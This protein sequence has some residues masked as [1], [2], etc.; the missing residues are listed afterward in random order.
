MTLVSTNLLP[1]L[2]AVI[3]EGLHMYLPVPGIL[4]RR[5]P[6]EGA[7]VAGEWVPGNTSVGV[8]QLSGYRNSHNFVEPFAFAPERF[9]PDAAA[10]YAGE[11]RHTLQPFSYGPHNCLGKNLAYNEMRSI[12]ARVVYEFDIELCPESQNWAYQRIFTLWQKPLLMVRLRPAP[13]LSSASP[14]QSRVFD[15]PGPEAGLHLL[16]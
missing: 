13:S 6:L 8:H 11:K 2:H 4:P 10:R 7:V 5:T 9:L 16:R 14:R 15:R 3:E 1:Y 12:L